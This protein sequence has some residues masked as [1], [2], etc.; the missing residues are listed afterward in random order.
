MNYQDDK[1]TEANLKIQEKLEDGNNHSYVN[2][3]NTTTKANN[4]IN[5]EFYESQDDNT[6]PT[7]LG[8]NNIAAVQINKKE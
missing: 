1:T 8:A 4:K 5:E 2:N 7:Y 6:T 3:K